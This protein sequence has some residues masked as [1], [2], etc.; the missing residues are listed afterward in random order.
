[1]PIFPKNITKPIWQKH[2]RTYSP[3]LFDYAPEYVK[4]L[5]H[6]FKILF[7][8]N[9]YVCPL[10]TDKYFYAEGDDIKG[11][12]EFSLDHVPPESVGGEF[13]ILT[14]KKCNNEA[15][16][17]EA[18]LLKILNFGSVPDKKT[19]SL[20]PKMIVRNKQTGEQFHGIVQVANN[21]ADIRFHEKAKQHNKKLKNFV[22]E[23]HEGKIPALELMV[24]AP[25]EDKT[26]RAL[27]KSAYLLCFACWGYEFV[28]SNNGER[29]RQVLKGELEYPTRI[30][31]VW[32]DTKKNI[33][34]KGLAILSKNGVREAFVVGL[35]LKNTT[36]NCTAGILI[37]NPTENGWE[38]LSELEKMVRAKTPTE[39]QC[40]TI[41]R[42]LGRR[43]YTYAWNIK[44]K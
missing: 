37:P 4:I 2:L 34:P 5:S 22:A 33:M 19:G 41:P 13:T 26:G 44:E 27:L 20:I 32:H 25:D 28:Y 43:G 17:Y 23:L 16:S 10:C 12:S 9:L 7:P 8:G 1:M 15:G 18:E 11:N 21:Q 36:D 42:T 30:P 29:L 35:E 38:K 39:F 14:C 31:A 3:T 24:P 6:E 40:M